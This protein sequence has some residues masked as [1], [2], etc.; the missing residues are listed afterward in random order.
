VLSES[1]A[2]RLYGS[3]PIGRYVIGFGNPLSSE[4]I[5]VVGDVKHRSLDEPLRSTVY[6]SFLQSP[7]R[8]AILVVRSQLPDADVI[9]AVR[10]EVARLD[11]NLPVYRIRSMRDVVNASPGVPARRVLTATFTAFALIAVVLCAIGLF[12]VVA[13]DVARRRA[14][15]A[16][17]IALGADPKRIL[18]TTLSQGVSMV[19]VGLLVGAVL[20]FW[21]T[22]ALGTMLIAPDR[23]DVL[24]IG[25][26]AILIVVT[27]VGAAF[28]AA[29]RAARTDPLVALRAE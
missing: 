24:S 1:L 19:V 2:E 10:E 23:L 27:G 20:S 21:A 16:L 5:G 18:R 9:G 26:A 14:E 29:L 15:L 7:S 12:G 22:R 17:R 28:P 6:V 13:H 4:V 8:N 11:G 3:N 25:L